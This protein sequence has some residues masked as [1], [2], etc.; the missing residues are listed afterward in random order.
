MLPSIAQISKAAE[1]LFVIEDLH[2]L[3]PHYD[4]TLMAWYNN[5]QNAWTGL[6]D[7]FDDDLKECGSIICSPARAHSVPVIFSS[8]RLFSQNTA[9]VSPFSGN[10]GRRLYS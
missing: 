1:G 2:N 3:G 6:E 8:G 7:R 10:A 5:F 4:K 9:G